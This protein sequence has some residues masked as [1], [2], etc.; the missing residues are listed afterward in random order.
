MTGAFLG[1]QRVK[2][3]VQETQVLS[4]GQEDAVEEEMAT[5]SSIPA[6]EIPCSEEPGRLQPIRLQR[7]GHD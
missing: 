1:A 4:L 3:P 7:V 6:W 5:Y 2:N